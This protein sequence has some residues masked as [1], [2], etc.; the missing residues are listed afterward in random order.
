MCNCNTHKQSHCCGHG[1]GPQLWST[2]KK[3]EVLEHHLECLDEKKKEIQDAIDEL[4]EQ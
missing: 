2:K 1:I 3:I 4:K